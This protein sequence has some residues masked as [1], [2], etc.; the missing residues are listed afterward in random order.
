LHA[1]VSTPVIDG[2]YVYGIGSYGQLRCL[3]AHTGKRIW[4]TMDLTVENARWASA[5]IVRNG[6][7]YFINNDR[8]ELIIARFSP[9]G[10]AEISRTELIKP[11]QPTERRRKRG[12]V[13]W[14]HPAYADRHIIVR[15]DEEIVR[16]S[17]AAE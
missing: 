4:E 9:D 12:A 10:Y 1:L 3:D 7:R 17:L 2:D 8:G 11:T 6:D 5:Q 15:N 13:H 14:S 16:Y